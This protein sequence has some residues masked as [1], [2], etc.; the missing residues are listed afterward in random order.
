MQTLSCPTDVM[1]FQWLSFDHLLSVR[2]KMFRDMECSQNTGPIHSK[3]CLNVYVNDA[4]LI[5][6][7]VTESERRKMGLFGTL[8]PLVSINPRLLDTATP[9]AQ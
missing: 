8:L 5:N 7:D 3:L 1:D 9:A 6:M 4:E 2:E